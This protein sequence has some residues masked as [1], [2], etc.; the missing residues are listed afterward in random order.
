[1]APTHPRP[2][3]V[4]IPQPVRPRD[5][6]P[7]EKARYVKEISTFNERKDA[8]NA[9]FPAKIAQWSNEQLAAIDGWRKSGPSAP[10]P[11]CSPAWT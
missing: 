6:S 9:D 11:R 4:E 1:M 3:A 8:A 2:V 10:R 7:E 5:D